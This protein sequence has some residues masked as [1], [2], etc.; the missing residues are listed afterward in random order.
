MTAVLEQ[1][2]SFIAEHQLWPRGARVV[3]AV[4]GG[5]DSVA[6]L[7]LLRELAST[8]E[9]ELAGL[10]HLHH[11]IRGAEADADAAFC[12][13]LA[14]RLGIPALMGDADVPA[15]AADAGVSLEVAGRRARQ[16]FYAEVMAS[17][18]ASRVAVAHTRD[19]QAET[20]LLR[21]ARG[22]GSAGLGGMA[23]RRGP[24]ARPVLDT[25][26]KSL[27]DFLRARGE[28]WREDATN[29]DRGIPRNLVRH[30]VMPHLRHINAQADRALA[31]AAEA[32]RADA[33]FLDTLANAAFIRSVEVSDAGQR[34]AV[35][36]AEL[37]RLARPLATRVAR[38]A[39]ETANPGRSYGLEEA[40]RLCAV[41]AGAAADEVPGLAMERS[42][43]KVVL[44]RRGA[45][46]VQGAFELA[47]A[48][49]GRVA[50]PRGVWALTAEGP[51]PVPATLVSDAGTAV[52]DAGLIG[53]R[54]IVRQRRPGDRLQP[55][56]A[57]GRKKVQDVL[58]DRKVPRDD[59]D[60]V[61]IVTTETGEIVWV[62]GH[63]LAAP[64][65]VTPLTTT[66]VVLTLR[67]A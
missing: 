54:L 22:A 11:H 16:R 62:A 52:V 32:L 36:A 53:S 42:G 38:F 21:L 63:V 37:A 18:T 17:A 27:R 47:L 33:E 65:R 50:A 3:A 1:V 29:L 46:D 2:R 24:I 34:V 28:G 66:V 6:M 31:R 30:E 61:P 5:S 67:R 60:V 26:R 9:L 7:L 57:R 10:A 14:A 44:V 35:D 43:A 39:L 58:V 55:L 15:A 13:D 56:G 19:D 48:V 23:P 49:P 25:T 51:M 64:F 45:Q 12:R 8:G 20:I 40:R 41:A 59:R 4:S